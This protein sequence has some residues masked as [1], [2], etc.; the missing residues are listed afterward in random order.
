MKYLRLVVQGEQG[1]VIFEQ[2]ITAESFSNQVRFFA[3]VLA[4]SDVQSAETGFTAALIPRFEGEP[5]PGARMASGE[6]RPAK[7]QA[8]TLRFDDGVSDEPVRHLSLEIRAKGE[9]TAKTYDIPSQVFWERLLRPR[10]RNVLLQLDLLGADERCEARLYARDDEEGRPGKERFPSLERRAFELIE[11][12]P[13]T[14][15]RTVLAERDP[16]VYN[17]LRVEGETG[18]DDIQIYVDHAAQERLLAQAAQPVNVESGGLLIG[19][20]YTCRKTAR[21]LVDVEDIIVSQYTVSTLS[22]LSYTFESWQAHIAQLEAEFQDKHIVGWYHTHLI[23]VGLAG[24]EAT[25]MFFSRH[26]HFVHQSFF[27]DEWYVAMVLDPKCRTM[28]FQ[29]KNGRIEQCGGYRVYGP[30]KES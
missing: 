23:E 28:F 17:V 26:D 30:D 24:G 16:S 18:P 12:E 7:I 27:P 15:S 11:L 8:L 2:D 13:E 9:T 4:R 22:E 6:A 19:H 29:W 25:S 20:A 14:R 3:L 1:D 21:A 10:V 5:Q